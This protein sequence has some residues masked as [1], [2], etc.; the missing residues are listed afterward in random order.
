MARPGW[1]ERN[2]AARSFRQLRRFLHV[3]NSDKVFGTHR[4]FR[5][6]YSSRANHPARRPYAIDS[7][8]AYWY[9]RDLRITNLDQ[10][11]PHDGARQATE[12][13]ERL[14]LAVVHVDEGIGVEHARHR[15]DPIV[16][17]TR[18]GEV[19]GGDRLE[20]SGLQIGN[21]AAASTR[22]RPNS[23]ARCVSHSRQAGP[24]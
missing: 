1:P 8:A 19:V 12:N 13:N 2:K 18:L 23:S 17:P 15:M 3:I 11:R 14:L 21:H 5:Q 20:Q 22:A 9:A 10:R 6:R 7:A 4:T 16:Q 24:A